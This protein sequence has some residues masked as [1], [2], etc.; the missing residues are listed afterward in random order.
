[1]KVG[2]YQNLQLKSYKRNNM[3]EIKKV[4]VKVPQSY[5]DFINKIF[6]I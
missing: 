6:E 4:T 5:L 2:H 3:Q 1:M